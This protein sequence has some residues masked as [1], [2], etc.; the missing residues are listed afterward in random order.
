MRIHIIEI[1]KKT[2][3][4][5]SYYLTANKQAGNDILEYK[6]TYYTYMATAKVWRSDSAVFK[7]ISDGIWILKK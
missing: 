7:D 1:C 2:D 4:Q 5:A 3:P 6:N